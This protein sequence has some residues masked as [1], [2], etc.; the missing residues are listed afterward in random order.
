MGNI[1][2]ILKAPFI[3]G[4]FSLSL[5]YFIFCIFGNEKTEK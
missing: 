5:N 1:F 3:Q 2:N 4:V